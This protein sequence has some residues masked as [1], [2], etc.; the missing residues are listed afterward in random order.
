MPTYYELCEL[1][2]LC[3]WKWTTLNGVNGYEVKSK[4]NNNSIFLPAA[5]SYI[6]DNIINLGEKGKYKSSELNS[7]DYEFSFCIYF[8]EMGIQYNS[9]LRFIGNSVRAVCP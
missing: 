5:G 8:S 9:Y 1:A 7:N 4:S 2:T 3:T 6:Y